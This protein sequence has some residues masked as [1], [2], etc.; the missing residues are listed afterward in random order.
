MGPIWTTNGDTTILSSVFGTAVGGLKV[1]TSGH[2]CIFYE[3][4][5]NADNTA[6]D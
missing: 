6:K 4:T 1:N 2:D 3:I 5:L